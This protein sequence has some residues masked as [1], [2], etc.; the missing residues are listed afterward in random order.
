[1]VT[2]TLSSVKG[3][4]RRLRGKKKKAFSL[5]LGVRAAGGSRFGLSAHPPHLAPF[6]PLPG[7]RLREKELARLQALLGSPTRDSPDCACRKAG[8]GGC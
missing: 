2:Q 6:L 8:R 3:G 5:R 1:M 7:R 4:E